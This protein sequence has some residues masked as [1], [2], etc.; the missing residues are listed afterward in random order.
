MPALSGVDESRPTLLD[1]MTAP[2][3]VGGNAYESLGRWSLVVGQ[4]DA[5]PGSQSM[6]PLAVTT[7]GGFAVRVGGTTLPR[8]KLRAGRFFKFLICAPNHAASKEVI[9]ETLWPDD[10][11]GVHNL[12]AAAHDVRQWLGDPQ[13]LTYSPPEY[14]LN[15]VEV[16]AE[17]FEERVRRG[18]TARSATAT[19][20]EYCAAL[21]IYAGPFLPDDLYVDWITARRERLKDRFIDTAMET[22]SYALATDDLKRAL[23]L[24]AQVTELDAAHENAVCVQMRSLAGLGRRAE[25]L[26]CFERLRVSLRR[27]LGCLPDPSTIAL[28]AALLAGQMSP[29]A[30]YG[31]SLRTGIR[32]TKA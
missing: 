30:D 7:L 11:N 23:E 31:R 15:S 27:E 1:F 25:A 3:A 9:A 26:R 20:D 10:Q 29:L 28:H 16:D 6:R 17:L 5:G 32:A 18:R 13:L 22:A 2:V 24:S 8:P 21:G 4:S 19:F 12:H 14:S